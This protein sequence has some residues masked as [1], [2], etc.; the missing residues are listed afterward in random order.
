MK[1]YSLITFYSRHR[2]FV[3]LETHNMRVCRK[4]LRALCTSFL[5]IG[6]LHLYVGF[7]LLLIAEFYSVAAVL[8]SIGSLLL[9][10]A[11]FGCQNAPTD[12][13][14]LLMIS[15]TIDFIL[16]A[17]IYL[18]GF[19][20]ASY[21]N[22][23]QIWMQHHW[24]ALERLREHKCCEAFPLALAHVDT[25]RTMIAWTG[26]CSL[27]LIL[28]KMYCTVRMVSLPIVVKYV[29]T[30][31][32]AIFA[33]LGI[34]VLIFALSVR[35]RISSTHK[36]SWIVILFVLVGI[37]L[38]VS[39]IVGFIGTRSKSRTLLLAYAITMIACFVALMTGTGGALTFLAHAQQSDYKD[40]GTIACD[41]K[42]F[43]CTNCT[44]TIACLGVATNA[45]GSNVPC[46][47]A[48]ALRETCQPHKTLLPFRENS[49]ASCSLC[50]EWSAGE[51][52]EVM[53]DAFVK[54]CAYGTL[55][56]LYIGI[57][58]VGSCVLRKSLAGYQ[59]DSV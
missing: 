37:S 39:S 15:F 2:A 4:V 49:I 40:S 22:I 36:H 17:C 29:L 41:L 32:H 45:N 5:F 56:C 26:F 6:L 52:H 28:S 43:Q 55:G 48:H 11:L 31:M 51:V 20:L 34:V 44:S 57:G 16:F 23:L 9:L 24:A 8:L 27:G 12:R 33:A 3:P 10:S 47:S 1:L 18:N 21:G 50:P 19:F 14:K 59:T 35:D 58:F 30:K 54:V 53:K 38:A 46:T 42:F 7:R 25:H 13:T